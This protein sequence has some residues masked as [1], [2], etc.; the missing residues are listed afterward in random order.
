MTAFFRLVVRDLELAFRDGG[1][2][3]TALGFFLMVVAMMPLGL[4][5]DLNLLSKLAPG[6]LWIAL[7]L[8]A[9]LSLPRMFESDFD[10]GALEVIAMGPLP[11]ELIVI[12]KAT[13]HWLTTGLPLVLLAPVLGL[14]LNLDLASAP[15][16]VTAMILGTPAISFLGA[17]G[18][19]LT[20]KAKRSGLLLALLVLPLYVPTLI[21]G[22]SALT[23]Q[24][25]NT[26]GAGS[27]LMI[28]S[29]VSLFALVLGPIASAAALRAQMQ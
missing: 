21:F 18:A 15:L 16:L 19:A 29:A 8:S 28:L 14:L 17:I 24:I 20:L 22:I 6:I 9:L 1:A 11:L 27:S 7:L 12:A 5:P 4:G 3:G 13:A 26:G 23:N 25:L 10:D 2:L